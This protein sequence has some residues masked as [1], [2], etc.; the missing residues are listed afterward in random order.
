MGI[1]RGQRERGEKPI[2]DDEALYLTDNGACY[3]G[4]HCGNMA[5]YTGCDISGQKVSKLTIADVRA[6]IA[7]YKWEPECET[8]GRKL[9]LIEVVK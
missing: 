8:C 3:C 5:R 2:L 6:S 1:T 7:T 4:K 9:T